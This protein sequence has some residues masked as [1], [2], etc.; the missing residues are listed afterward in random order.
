MQGAQ[1][2]KKNQPKINSSMWF[3][4]TKLYSLTVSIVKIDFVF[5][6]PGV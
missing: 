4:G 6:W 5:N 3:K 1:G 2:P